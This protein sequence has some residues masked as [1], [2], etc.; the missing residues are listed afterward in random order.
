MSTRLRDFWGSGVLGLWGP[1][2]KLVV[3]DAKTVVTSTSSSI[4]SAFKT[5]L[6]STVFLIKLNMHRR[7]MSNQIFYSHSCSSPNYCFR[8]KVAIILNFMISVVLRTFIE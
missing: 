1:V 7:A 6:Q 2:S 3:F 4:N 5:E 8:F